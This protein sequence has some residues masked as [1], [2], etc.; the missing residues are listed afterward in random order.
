ME[1]LDHIP[2]RTSTT[3]QGRRRILVAYRVL[4]TVALGQMGFFGQVLNS[5]ICL[6]GRLNC[7]VC[8]Y[9]GPGHRLAGYRGY[10]RLAFG[11]Y[12]A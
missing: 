1:K 9:I 3:P 4:P 7:E 8:V 6:L 2:H 11:E 10:V 12:C 5:P